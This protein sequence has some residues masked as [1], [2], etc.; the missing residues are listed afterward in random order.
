M[1]RKWIFLIFVLPLIVLL[2]LCAGLWSASNQLLFPSWH[3]VAKDI[4]VC[5]QE[6]K[7]SWGNDCGN[8]RTTK[9][10]EFEEIKIPSIN[11]Y[12]L[13]AW[14][15]ETER[16]GFL[17]S[18][19]AILLVHGGG[20]D[21]R[22]MTRHIRFFLKNKLDV[23]TFDLGCHGEAPCPIE[24]LTYGHRES[25]D[26]FSAY[27]YLSEKYNK[28]YAMGSSVGAGSILIAL[29][30]MPRLNAVIVENPM[31]SFQRLIFDSPEAKS[32]PKRFVEAMIGLSMLRGRFDGLMSAKNSLSLVKNIPIYFIHSKKDR[33]VS[34][35]QTQNLF[36]SYSGPKKIWLSDLGDHGTIREA[37]P[38]EYERRLSD[39]LMRTE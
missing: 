13:P 3:G 14:R 18:R 25:R 34:Y 1:K 4:S 32:V 30:W 9:E 37:N 17:R 2:L 28:V 26:V 16:N 8:L 19:G 10:Y 35:F 12:E 6:A 27:H 31:E 29:P 36:D 23:F 11:G 7:E 22:E 20:S 21:R 38:N 33:V 15:I 24:G 39:F 5:K